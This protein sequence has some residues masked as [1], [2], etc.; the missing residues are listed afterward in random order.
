MA[1]KWLIIFFI[2]FITGCSSINKKS[3][4]N[5]LKIIDGEFKK[6]YDVWDFENA[7]KRLNILKENNIKS[8]NFEYVEKNIKK[9]V[10][11]KEELEKIVVN[12]KQDIEQNN[13][14]NIKKYIDK[15]ILNILKF[16]EMSKY[17]FSGVKV[18]NKKITYFQN[19]ADT[20]YAFMYMDEIYYYAVKFIYKND[21]WFISN[22]IEKVGD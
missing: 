4:I 3:S 5:N 1:V 17:D 6:Y 9:R 2:I 20:I 16:N 19:E 13:I 8:V 11:K 22:F 12:I 15:T 21:E 14:E 10:N 7:E 18:Y